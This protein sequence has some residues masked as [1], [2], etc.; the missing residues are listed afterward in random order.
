MGEFN[1]KRGSLN[2]RAY[3]TLVEYISLCSFTFSIIVWLLFAWE[4]I[5]QHQ[6][7]LAAICQCPLGDMCHSLCILKG[8]NSKPWM[9]IIRAVMDSLHSVTVFFFLC[10]AHCDCR[11]WR[12]KRSVGLRRWL[13]RTRRATTVRWLP[14]YPPRGPRLQNGRGPRT[15]MHQNELCKWWC[16]CFPV[17][18]HVNCLCQ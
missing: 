2:S 5:V 10:I 7:V 14:T 17:Y 3:S 9:Y 6:Y 12:P 15:L 16:Y 1:H 8:W 4:A 13:R 18:L 11:K